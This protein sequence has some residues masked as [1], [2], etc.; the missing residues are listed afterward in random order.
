[1][2]TITPAVRRVNDDVPGL[3]TPLVEQSLREHRLAP[4][5]ETGS[6]PHP[7]FT[8]PRALL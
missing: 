1:M 2:V 6:L 5:F 4:L 3:L 7:S 8:E